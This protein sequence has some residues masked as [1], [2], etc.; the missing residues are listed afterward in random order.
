M[1]GTSKNIVLV[2]ALMDPSEIRNTNLVC[3]RGVISTTCR[4]R[5]WPDAE[6]GGGLPWMCYHRCMSALLWVERGGRYDAVGQGMRVDTG[7]DICV[8]NAYDN[9]RSGQCRMMSGI[10]TSFYKV[11]G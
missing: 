8:R 4:A 2:Y 10:R 5:V 9:Q 1:S 11:A 6:K 7:Y 3:G